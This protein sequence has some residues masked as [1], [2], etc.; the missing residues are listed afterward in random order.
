MTNTIPVITIDGP[1]GTG[2][3]TI[4]HRLANY[5]GWHILDSGMIYRV[6][7]YAAKQERI[8][9][10]DEYALIHLSQD[11]DFRFSKE[12]E[13]ILNG[14]NIYAQV[15]SESCG[16]DASRIAVHQKLREALLAKQRAFSRAPGLV[17][18]GRDMGTVVFPNA[19]LKIYLEA[20]LEER[21]NRRYCQL[22]S[23]ENHGTLAAVLSE[24]AIRDQ[25]DGSRAYAP[26]RPAEDAIV[27]DT[28]GLS[29]EE[30]FQK[31]LTLLKD[32]GIA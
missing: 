8:S 16:Q 14:E 18:D 11:L 25:R 5:L 1:S 3:G 6:L 22:K 20:S 4:C 15:R 29:I 30:V 31:I 23:Q 28:T 10:D 27:V 9:L 24:L 7:A 26:M 19:V 17:T 2:K 32:K 12:G 21:A 13:L